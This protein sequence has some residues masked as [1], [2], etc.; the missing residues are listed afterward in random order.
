[1]QGLWPSCC[2]IV[3]QLTHHGTTGIGS[4]I[5]AVPKPSKPRVCNC[6]LCC[7]HVGPFLQLRLRV[8]LWMVPRNQRY[9]QQ[10]F[11]TCFENIEKVNCKAHRAMKVWKTCVYDSPTCVDHPS[12]GFLAVRR[13]RSNASRPWKP[14]DTCTGSA[15]RKKASNQPNHDVMQLTE[16]QNGM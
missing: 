16:V 4:A 2:P 8:P 5:A 7:R 10:S 11:L 6:L 1:M 12:R 9:D 14:Q 3:L 15:Y 13:L